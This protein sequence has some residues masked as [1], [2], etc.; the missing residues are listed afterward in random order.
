MPNDPHPSRMNLQYKLALAHTAAALAT[1]LIAE[2]IA[3]VIPAL[4]TQQPVFTRPGWGLHVTLVIVVAA[5]TG[6]LFGVWAGRRVARRIQHTLEISRAWLRGNLS[7]RTADS[8][9]DDLGLLAG[10][11][12][13]LAEHLE[14]D[15]QDLDTLREHNARLT[16]QV[17]AL[18]VVE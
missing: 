13:L 7:L 4:T 6:P 9:L 18:A 14:Q 11:L 2:G 10:Q 3:L 17:R 5:L 12:N 16:D 8:T 1:V 15:E